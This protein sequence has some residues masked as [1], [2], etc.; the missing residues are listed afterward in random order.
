VNAR[1]PLQYLTWLGAR[2]AGL[3]AFGLAA[4]GV[5]VGLA[6]STSK[7]GKR[8]RLVERRDLHEQLA[9]AALVAIALHAVLLLAD[10]WLRPGV[11]G[12]LVPFAT[13]Y[14]PLWTGLG[15]IAA[16]LAT[17]FGLSYYARRLVGARRWRKLHRFMP[18]VYVLAAVHMLGA[19]S[20]RGTIW[21]RGLVVATAVPIAILLALRLAE[22]YRRAGAAARSAREPAARVVHEDRLDVLVREHPLLAERR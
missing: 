20:D 3:V 1:D 11:V 21:L 8:R 9:L 19:G 17:G 6:M 5:I 10:R 4:A 14:R 15:I 13:P 7:A 18:I 22:A 2:S 16:Y 12:I